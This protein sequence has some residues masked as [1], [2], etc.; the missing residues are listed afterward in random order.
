MGL[1]PI[2]WNILR[3][4]ESKADKN[5]NDYRAEFDVANGIGF[6]NNLGRFRENF[7]YA[8]DKHDLNFAQRIV[9]DNIHILGLQMFR[10]LHDHKI[11]IP[12]EKIICTQ[13]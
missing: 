10:Q 4:N 5:L 7:C 8:T 3:R 11:I 2:F 9:K 12:Q 13:K 1:A 6:V